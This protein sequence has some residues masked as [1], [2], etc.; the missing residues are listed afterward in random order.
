MNETNESSIKQMASPWNGAETPY[1]S[2]TAAVFPSNQ[3][4]Y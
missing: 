2:G 3:T 4:T 1:F